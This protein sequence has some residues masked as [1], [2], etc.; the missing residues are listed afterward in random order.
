MWG[1]PSLQEAEQRF[2]WRYQENNCLSNGTVFIAVYDGQVIGFRGY[3]AQWFWFGGN[4]RIVLS[5]S[6][7]IVAQE[8]RR[9]GVFRTLTDFSMRKISSRKDSADL[10]YYL[11]LSSNSLS[12]PGYMKLGWKEL[13]PKRY[14]T[15]FSLS[16]LLGFHKIRV[17]S[18]P[19]FRR[20]NGD[21]ILKISN[22]I[23]LTIIQ[24]I[25]HFESYDA[26][27]DASSDFYKWRYRKPGEDRMFVALFCGKIPTAYM[28]VSVNCKGSCA[29]LDYA[30]TSENTFRLMIRASIRHIG[31]RYLRLFIAGGTSREKRCLSKAGFVSDE[32]VTWL[33]NK[34]KE[35][36]L[37]RGVDSSNNQLSSDIKKLIFDTSNWRILAGEIH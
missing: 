8:Y 31:C 9:F 26:F 33:R 1:L 3:V 36:V 29:V 7:A 22:E 25:K 13:M 10:L 27:H 24:I 6:D 21:N 34:R 4:R 5:P 16:C 37:I 23:D 15:A 17:F 19:W 30:A 20:L 11:N 2:V 12:A 35:A 32:I 18:E 28:I 14:L